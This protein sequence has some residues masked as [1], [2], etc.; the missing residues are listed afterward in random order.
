LWY[1][2]WPSA[3]TTTT[4]A[5]PRS[6]AIKSPRAPPPTIFPDVNE[7]NYRPPYLNDQAVERIK[8]R[9]TIK[10]MAVS[11]YYVITGILPTLAMCRG[12]RNVY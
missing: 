4:S 2:R 10:A 7:C 6:S 11:P 12:D 3:L 9:G 8:H 1:S 5:P